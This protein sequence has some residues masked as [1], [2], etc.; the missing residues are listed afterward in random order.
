MHI[1]N[2]K[3]PTHQFPYGVT[4]GSTLHGSSGHAGGKLQW[5]K[6]SATRNNKKGQ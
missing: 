6:I 1:K 3:C 4:I 5:R 2:S